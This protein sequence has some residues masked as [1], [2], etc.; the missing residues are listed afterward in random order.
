MWPSFSNRPKKHRKQTQLAVLNSSLWHYTV[1]FEHLQI[2]HTLCYNRYSLIY[3]PN[4][5]GM[6]DKSFWLIS[7][8]TAWT[9]GPHPYCLSAGM[10]FSLSRK[11]GPHPHMVQTTTLFSGHLNWLG[12]RNG[13]KKTKGSH[14]QKNKE[15]KMGTM[16]PDVI[17]WGPNGTVRSLCTHWV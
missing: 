10:L 6:R 14:S 7:D 2:V 12:K 3:G 11:S 16:G 13:I 8:H 15:R 9:R 1:L 17:F 5:R 4:A